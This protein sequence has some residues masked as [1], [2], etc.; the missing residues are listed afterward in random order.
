M[1]S[2]VQPL[3]QHTVGVTILRLSGPTFRV[4]NR[5]KFPG[6]RCTLGLGATYMTLLMTPFSG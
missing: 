5:S 6:P 4:V 1:G 3:E 2:G